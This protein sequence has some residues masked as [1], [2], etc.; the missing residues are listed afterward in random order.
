MD[1]LEKAKMELYKVTKFAEN[2]ETP[3]LVIT[4]NHH[5]ISLLLPFPRAIQE[6]LA[7]IK[8]GALLFS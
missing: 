5:V 3:L 4:N 1:W 2:Q 6:C 8:P 7:Q